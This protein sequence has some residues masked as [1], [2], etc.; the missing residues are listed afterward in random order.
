MS[1]ILIVD[2]HPLYR[3]GMVGALKKELSDAE[4]LEAGSA[5]EGFALLEARHDVDMVLI[6]LRLPGMDGFAALAQF[7]ANHPSVAR[8]LL[9]GYDEPDLARRAF[10][11][12]ASAFIHKSMTVGE[13]ARALR[14]V[15]D[16][17]V[18]LPEPGAAAPEGS[19]LTLRQL[20]VLRLLGEG[21][22]N[23]EIANALDITERT[24]KAHVAAIFEALG[25]DN[26]TQAVVAAQRMGL[27]GSAVS[28]A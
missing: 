1:R 11:S 13:V 15:L 16:G 25:A 27:I 9:S 3:E 22:T 6:D 21:Y 23:K 18:Y 19:P 7:G 17:G 5:E 12:G 8:V 24:A 26:R 4:V 14:V 2:D 28:R 20:E 10:D